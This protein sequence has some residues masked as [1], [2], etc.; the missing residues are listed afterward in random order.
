MKIGIIGSGVVGFA[1]GKGFAKL[2]HNVIFHDVNENRL[3]E[4][5]RKGFSC[6]NDISFIAENADIFFLCV[7]TPSKNRKIDLSYIKSASKLLARSLACSKKY[8]LVVVKSSVIP[9]TTEKIIIP[10]FEKNSGKKAGRDF[11]VC[12]NPEFLRAKFAYE[13]FMEPDRI[14]IGE[15]NKKSGDVLKKL[16]E[17]F[18]CPIIRTDLRTAEMSKYANNCFYSTKISFFNEIHLMSK[19]LGIDSETVRKIVQLDKFYSNHPWYHGKK[20]GGA[21]LPKDLDAAISFFN[22]KHIHNP[23]LLKAVRKVNE[24]IAFC[25]A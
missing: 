10:L 17:T 2:K 5:K 3:Q 19:E 25:G 6:T 16:Y 14:V 8:F 9:T 4:I 1:V 7:P 18:K 15:F 20:F 24:Q 13:D 21:C 22:E 11:G 23:I 12:F